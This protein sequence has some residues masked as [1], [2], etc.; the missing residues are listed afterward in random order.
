M[1]TDANVLETE[2][3]C[4]WYLFI[5]CSF[6]QTQFTSLPNDELSVSVQ[7]DKN[8]NSPTATACSVEAVCLH[9]ASLMVE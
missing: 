2:M 5:R 8:R 9:C 4:I 3:I 1:I 6:V 7:R